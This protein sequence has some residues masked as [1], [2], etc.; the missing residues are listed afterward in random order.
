MLHARLRIK[1]HIQL[2]VCDTEVREK[3]G[4]GNDAGRGKGFYTYEH[5]LIG[6]FVHAYQPQRRG[7]ERGRRTG[8][9][10]AKHPMPT[11]AFFEALL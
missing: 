5:L 4:K 9:M 1:Q 6:W 7:I 10:K 8:G 2:G 3:A 11:A